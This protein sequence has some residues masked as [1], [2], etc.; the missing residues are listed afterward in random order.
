M[1][2]CGFDSNSGSKRLSPAMVAS[3][4]NGVTTKLQVRGLLGAPQSVKTQLPVQQPPGTEPLPVK[5]LA[6][7]IWAFWSDKKQSKPFFALGAAKTS[8][9]LVIIYFDAQGVVLDCQSEASQM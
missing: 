6:S 3:I 5:Y 7:E 8:R 2:G 9:Y 4:R 1:A